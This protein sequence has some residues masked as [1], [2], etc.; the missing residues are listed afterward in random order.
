[1][2]ERE[3]APESRLS[4][5]T[6]HRKRAGVEAY[7]IVHSP[8]EQSVHRHGAIAEVFIYHGPDDPGWIL[9]VVAEDGT[10]T[11]WDDRFSTDQK[12]LEAALHAIDTDGLESFLEG[13]GDEPDSR[14]S[15]APEEQQRLREFLT[16]RGAK[17]LAWCSGL[18]SALQ[19]APTMV[20]PS[21][22]LPLVFNGEPEFESQEEASEIIGL[23]M[24]AYGDAI[25][26]TDEGASLVCPGADD[27]DACEQWAQGYLA[28]VNAAD[29]DVAMATKIAFQFMV[30]TA[31]AGDLD[32]PLF[33][34]VHANWA[35]SAQARG[36]DDRS[37]QGMLTEFR[38]LL[39][40][41]AIE[42][43]DHFEGA[44]AVPSMPMPANS[45]E[46]IARN[47][48]CPCGSGRKYKKCCLM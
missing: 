6:F 15:G 41:V 19:T 35:K 24:Y 7:P 1:M 28:G 13:S 5:A 3:R 40:H 30:I 33:E 36:L 27:P 31:L 22:W 20:V 45:Q 9:E 37:E 32:E 8:L 26:R 12:A 29:L 47:A 14:D 42:I 23:L 17:P 38:R 46:K 10:S 2:R 11:V 48:P 25:G 21:A 16:A 44:R 34:R 4:T 39:P 18:F 43:Y